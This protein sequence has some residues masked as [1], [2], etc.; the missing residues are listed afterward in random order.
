MEVLPMIYI[1]LRGLILGLLLTVLFE[2]I[3]ALLLGIRKTD[4]LLFVLLANVMTNPV[5]VLIS[6]LCIYF[7]SLPTGPITLLLELWAVGAE[8][9]AYRWGKL[10]HPLILSVFLNGISYLLGNAINF[11]M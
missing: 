4:D 9:L 10:T 3:L 5:V 7:T 8:F 6:Y 11:L 2:I 1:F